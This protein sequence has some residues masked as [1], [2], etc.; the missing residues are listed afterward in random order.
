MIDLAGRP[1]RP[2]WSEADLAPI[3]GFVAEETGLAVSPSDGRFRTVLRR[4]LL[5]T[6][7]GSGAY[8]DLVDQGRGATALAERRLLTEALLIH[9]TAIVRYP[10]LFEALIQDVIPTLARS[11]R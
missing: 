3:V 5:A 6:G 7:L 8:A 9:E 2:A 11:L 4:R 10:A 1:E